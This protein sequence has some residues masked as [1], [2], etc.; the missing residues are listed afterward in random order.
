MKFV[1]HEYKRTIVGNGKTVLA[2]LEKDK[3]MKTKRKTED[4][5]NL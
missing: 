3:H 1:K 2:F 5:S 4:L